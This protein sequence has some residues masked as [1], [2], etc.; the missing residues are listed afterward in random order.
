[1]CPSEREEIMDAYH[2]AQR[3][4]SMNRYDEA[5]RYLRSC[6]ARCEKA[7]DRTS[8]E[9]L[10]GELAMCLERA[11]RYDD[12][13]GALS[14]LIRIVAQQGATRKLAIVHHN[15]GF[16]Y[17]QQQD[18]AAAERE[19]ARSG[20][21]AAE[22]GDLRGQGVSMAMRAQVLVAMGNISEGLTCFCRALARLHEGAAPELEHVAIHTR[23]L[24]RRHKVT[25][26]SSLARQEITAP[27]V[28]RLLLDG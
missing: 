27:D 11:G 28:L 15:L 7:G 19:F 21:I 20:Q 12:S 2:A 13:A 23:D 22:V 16:L 4:M 1:M 9:T 18:L 3:L 25:D 6:F 5:A 26:F 24:A 8:C 10:L 14:D 17:E